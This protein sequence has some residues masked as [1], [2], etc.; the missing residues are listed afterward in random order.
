MSRR[1]AKRGAEI[2]L[3]DGIRWPAAGP[4]AG[5]PDGEYR[6]GVRP[7]Y[8]SPHPAG[9]GAVRFS[10]RVLVT[11]LSGS[12]SVAHFD[13][14]GRTWVAQSHG[15]HPYQ[16][17]ATHDFFVDVAG[18]LYFDTGGRL[19][20]S[21]AGEAMAKIGLKALRHSY[22]PNPQAEADW[23]LKRIDLDWEDGGAYALL[24]PSGCGK[25][26]LLNIISGLV[27]PTEGRVLF[28]E[29]DVTALPPDQRHIAQ[30]FQ[31]PVIYD[32]MTRL[33]QPGLSAEEPGRRP[34]TGSTRGCARSPRCW[35]SRTC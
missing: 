21:G 26:T 15:V 2:L 8:V 12:E 1:V 4:V 24:G 5:M 32:T 14:N 6:V 22:H 18:C 10:G 13:L 25:T 11:E 23:A 29:R 20:A 9:E 3:D 19:V 30:V 16:V 17:G 34:R 28:D 31:F 33:R 7:H 27:V 35:N